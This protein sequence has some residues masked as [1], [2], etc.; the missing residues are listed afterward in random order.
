MSTKKNDGEGASMTINMTPEQNRKVNLYQAAHNIRKKSEAAA[1]MI[2][3]H[4][5]S[6]EQ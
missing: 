5:I 6:I 1:L 2:G 3:E 4:P